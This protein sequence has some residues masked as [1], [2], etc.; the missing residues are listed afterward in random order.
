M[1]SNATGFRWLTEL[2]ADPGRL[3]HTDPQHIVKRALA[4]GI[5]GIDL[6][7][8]IAAL[9]YSLPYLD[10][11]Q[12]RDRQGLRQ[13]F[14]SFFSDA[15]PTITDPNAWRF[16][17][18]WSQPHSPSVGF[19]VGGYDVTCLGAYLHD[20]RP[21]LALGRS[22]GRVDLWDP[23][24]GQL[25]TKI[26]GLGARVSKL[27][28]CD[29]WLAAVTFDGALWLIDPGSGEA[30]PALPRGT[31]H[32]RTTPG[33]SPD[34]TLILCGDA[35]GAVRLWEVTAP[36]I[37]TEAGPPYLGHSSQ[38]LGT[39]AWTGPDGDLVAS[40]S[41]DEL[42]IWRLDTRK[43]ITS[44]I[45]CRGEC[46]GPVLVDGMVAF[47]VGNGVRLWREGTTIRRRVP[48]RVRNLA[49]ITGSYGSAWLA[50]DHGDGV[51]FIDPA[52]GA[53]AAPS[54]R[55]GMGEEH[56]A[57][58]RHNG[59]AVV[60]TKC[61]PAIRLYHPEVSPRL[62]RQ[63]PMP[64]PCYH[65]LAYQFGADTRVVTCGEDAQVWD[66]AT[67][68]AV[69]PRFR[70]L[71]IVA[72]YTTASGQPRLV[73][74]DED[75]TLVHC[76]ET[77]RML[78]RL[79]RLDHRSDLHV[80][81]LDGHPLLAGRFHHEGIDIINPE[82]GQRFSTLPSPSTGGPTLI[83]SFAGP[84]DVRLVTATDAGPALIW[85]PASGTTLGGPVGESCWTRLVGWVG[86]NGPRIATIDGDEDDER[87][88]IWDA[89]TGDVARQIQTPGP[90]PVN[91]L[92][93]PGS[94]P[95]LLTAQNNGMVRLWNPESGRQ[96]Y[97]LCLPNLNADYDSTL[98]PLP[99][100]SL[101]VGFHDQWGIIELPATLATRL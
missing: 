67:G 98:T 41:D 68:K 30:R 65:V 18:V 52:T 33:T 78:R 24:T 56:L 6:P 63:R 71:R 15:P 3:D 85:D 23:A 38:V 72:T 16:R 12:P 97:S 91:L 22:D 26:E 7:P 89:A 74:V 64:Y 73:S 40:L 66:A 37:L 87:V 39:V 25:I 46:V 17:H 81:T 35:V 31:T 11:T 100:G 48:S 60:A 76:P 44:P 43:D 29:D 20:D 69:G 93:L 54:L 94:P 1:A 77:S 34:G 32:Y 53:S 58:W 28:P 5:T 61:G 86:P 84:N 80:F 57:V 70:G 82:T 49:A 4:D 88:T 42:R 36:G 75:H 45:R 59:K 83:T 19:V 96:V 27:V 99:D 2:A 13:R 92:L 50:V 55:L 10:R 51:A 62:S 79:P 21:G 101:A 95:H 8:A 9:F 90:A 14:S 47:G